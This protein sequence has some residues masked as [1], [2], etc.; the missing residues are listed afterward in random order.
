MVPLTGTSE[1][2]A[3]LQIVVLITVT[4]ATGLTVTV[5]EN[6]DPVQDPA[7]GVTIYVM[8]LAILVVLARVPPIDVTPVPEAAP[9]MPVAEGVDQE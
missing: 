7:T 4:A 3:P 9:V 6:T 5:T 2:E 1:K 8:V